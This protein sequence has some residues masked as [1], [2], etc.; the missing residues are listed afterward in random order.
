MSL[1]LRPRT[2]AE[3]LPEY[4]FAASL[5]VADTALRYLPSSVRVEIKWPNDVLIDGRKTS[6]INLPAQLD[7]GRVSSAVLGIGVNLNLRRDELPPELR[8]LATS[9]LEAGGEPVNRLE[10][11]ESLLVRLEEA[12]GQLRSTGF[13]SVLEGWKK[14]F[15]MQGERVRIGGPGVVQE[16][17]GSVEGLDPSGALLV[18]SA[19]GLE[20]IL[21]GDVTLISREARTDGATGD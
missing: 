7:G 17:E 4:V 19:A 2:G 8:S 9:L 18:R 13:E 3:R 11:A 1:L 16:I 15:R 10:F 21:A 14:Y 20:R 6:G 5:A 12:I